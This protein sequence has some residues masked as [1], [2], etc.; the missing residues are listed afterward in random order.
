MEEKVIFDETEHSLEVRPITLVFNKSF[1]ESVY[2]E[3]AMI[4]C[5]MT[6]N[7][8]KT[9]QEIDPYTA[10]LFKLVVTDFPYEIKKEVLD[11]C[12]IGFKHL[13][14][15]FSLSIQ[16]IIEKKKFGWKYPESNI[17]PKYQA[18]LADAMIILSNHQNSLIKFI[19]NVNENAPV[20]I[21]SLLATEEEKQ[22]AID[23]LK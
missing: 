9:I 21:D 12:L 3:R 8:Y 2:L 19:E 1:G 22:K 14:G 18:N 6:L 4:D 16:M 7:H 11:K 15:L 20:Q 5:E 23:R 17:H 13:I 10:K